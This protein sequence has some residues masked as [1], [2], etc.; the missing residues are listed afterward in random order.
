MKLNKPSN[1]KVNII[2]DKLK[3]LIRKKKQ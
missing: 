3:I 1:L 2:I